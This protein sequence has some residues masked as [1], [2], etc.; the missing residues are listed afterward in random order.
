LRNRYYDTARLY[1]PLQQAKERL[2]AASRN[3]QDQQ[4]DARVPGES[5]KLSEKNA[6]GNDH[7][8]EPAYVVDDSRNNGIDDDEDSQ[9]KY[10]YSLYKS[11]LSNKV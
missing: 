4:P 2:E 8:Q 10:I 5:T 11:R 7:N 9:I 6:N 1:A 3:I